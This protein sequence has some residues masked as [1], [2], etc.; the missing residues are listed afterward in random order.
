M[1][2]PLELWGTWLGLSCGV[3]SLGR[4]PGLAGEG[5]RILLIN[6]GTLRFFA[7]ET[8]AVFPKRCEI[9]R[10]HQVL[11]RLPEGDC[12]GEIARSGLMVRDNPGVL[13]WGC[14]PAWPR[15]HADMHN[16]KVLTAESAPASSGTARRLFNRAKRE[17]SSQGALSYRHIRK[18]V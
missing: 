7:W 16:D 11:V 8:A 12:I 2:L 9:R 13:R 10:C 3:F 18:T 4:G 14:E 5:S 1:T 15:A 6:G 17:K